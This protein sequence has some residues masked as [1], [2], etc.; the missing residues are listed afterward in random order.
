MEGWRE[1]RRSRQIKTERLVAGGDGEREG[2]RGGSLGDKERSAVLSHLSSRSLARP[3]AR[4]GPL[5]GVPRI[6]LPLFENE[7]RLPPGDLGSLTVPAHVRA[8]VCRGA[9]NRKQTSPRKSPFSGLC[10]LFSGRRAGG[11]TREATRS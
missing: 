3:L 5:P 8:R 9:R 7:R 11:G 2:E 6:L 10:Q 4:P 1:R